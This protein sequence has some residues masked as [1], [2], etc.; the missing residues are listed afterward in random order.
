M[1]FTAQYAIGG[2]GG[3]DVGTVFAAMVGVHALIGIGEGL[4]TAAVVGAVLAVRPDLVTALASYDIRTDRTAAGRGAASG[5][6]VAGL[7]AA[8][9]LVAFVAPNASPNPDGLE[10]VAEDTGFIQ[11]AE[12]HS[13]RGPLADYGV[14]GI[15]SETLGTIISG[16][17]GIVIT[18]ALGLILA[19]VARRTRR[20]AV[21]EEPIHT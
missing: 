9:V 16:V 21:P 12:D 17:V 14:A 10:R 6:V 4:I 2:Q 15:E 19:G 5:F 7:V 11:R 13:I 3:V 1:A 8:F 18:F 20:D